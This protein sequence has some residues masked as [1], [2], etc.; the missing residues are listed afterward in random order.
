[1]PVAKETI[2]ADYKIDGVGGERGRRHYVVASVKLSMDKVTS[3]LIRD[4]QFFKTKESRS[5]FF[6]HWTQGGSYPGENPCQNFSEPYFHP[7]PN[8]GSALARTKAGT[9]MCWNRMY[10]A[11]KGHVCACTSALGG[12]FTGYSQP[13]RSRQLRLSMKRYIHERVTRFFTKYCPFFPV[14][15]HMSRIFLSC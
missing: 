11:E 12:G 3:C 7:L 8:A 2:T 10:T 15:Q 13:G 4:I 1:M 14:F 9:S 6:S 5:N